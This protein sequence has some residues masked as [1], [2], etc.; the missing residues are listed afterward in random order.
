MLFYKSFLNGNNLKPQI[1]LVTVRPTASPAATNPHI[2]SN[3]PQLG[4]TH[5]G[6]SLVILS[7]VCSLPHLSLMHCKAFERDHLHSH[8]PL[9][10]QNIQPCWT[11]MSK[12]GKEGL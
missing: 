10:S 1:D 7:Q 3:C 2:S 8:S 4:D 9:E 11:V 6:L 12:E 5:M